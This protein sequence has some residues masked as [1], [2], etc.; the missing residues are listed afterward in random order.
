MTGLKNVWKFNLLLM[1][2]LVNMS[3]HM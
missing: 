2:L 3:H 1:I